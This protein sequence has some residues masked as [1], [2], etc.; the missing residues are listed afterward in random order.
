[1]AIFPHFSPTLLPRPRK[2]PIYFLTVW[3]CLVWTFHINGI[4]QYV[5][6]CVWLLSF[7]LIFSRVI[8]GVACIMI[9]FLFIVKKYPFVQINHLS[10]Y[11]FIHLWAF[12]LAPLLTIINIAMNICAQ[13]FMWTC[14]LVLGNIPRSEISGSW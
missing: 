11:S 3:N 8:H 13:V 9:S 7:S 10:V 5:V 12:G 6:F 14:F 1:M 4:I 2:P